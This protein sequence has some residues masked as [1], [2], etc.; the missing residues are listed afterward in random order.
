MYAVE[1]NVPLPEEEGV[2][3][4]LPTPEEL[5]AEGEPEVSTVITDKEFSE[6]P[7]PDLEEPIPVSGR[8]EDGKWAKGFQQEGPR[9][10]TERRRAR[11]AKLSDDFLQDLNDVWLERGRFAL[12]AV[13][14]HSPDK[15]VQVVAQ[16]LAKQ[17]NVTVE[18]HAH[19]SL[20]TIGLQE[21]SRRTGELLARAAER[22]DPLSLPN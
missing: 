15:F 4:D 12:E 13:A 6:T 8:H 10:H 3:P 22:D 7:Q 21:I 1:S 2:N 16:L 9:V 14:I 18:Q 20:D 11:M 17:D 5:I 19:I